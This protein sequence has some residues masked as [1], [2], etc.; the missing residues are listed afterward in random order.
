[1]RRLPRASSNWNHGGGNVLDW[2]AGISE[3]DSIHSSG[4]TLIIAAA[5]SRPLIA[6]VAGRF[7]LQP[8]RAFP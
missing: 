4:A 1:M 5:S 2:P 6:K 8:C 3:A 7:T